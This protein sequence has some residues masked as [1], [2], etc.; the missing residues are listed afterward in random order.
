M[1][2][3]NI[4]KGSNSRIIKLFVKDTITVSEPLFSYKINRQGFRRSIS[5][6]IRRIKSSKDKNNFPKGVEEERL[7]DRQKDR[8][9]QIVKDRRSGKVVHQEDEPLSRHRSG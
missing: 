6:F 2:N 8:Y 7:I 3:P 9:K 5:E 4:K 1:S